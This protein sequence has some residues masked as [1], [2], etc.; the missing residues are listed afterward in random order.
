M[1]QLTFAGLAL[2]AASTVALLATEMVTTAHAGRTDGKAY[3]LA[4]STGGQLRL[5][6]GSGGPAGGWSE[7]AGGQRRMVCRGVVEIT[8]V[9]VGYNCRQA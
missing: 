1:D 4:V 2:V 8:V 3:L 5:D 9:S 7:A 6:G